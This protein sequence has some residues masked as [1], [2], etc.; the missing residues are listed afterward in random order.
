[1]N[2]LI[3]AQG[4]V[5][6]KHIGPVNLDFIERELKPAIAALGKAAP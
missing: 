1:M 4:V 3:D 5:R 2:F 6:M